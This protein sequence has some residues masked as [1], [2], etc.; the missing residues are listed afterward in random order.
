MDKEIDEFLE[1][2]E[3]NPELVES[4]LKAEVIGSNIEN[5]QKVN[6]AMM[7]PLLICD[8]PDIELPKVPVQLNFLLPTSIRKSKEPYVVNIKHD[9]N[10]Y[11]KLY[12]KHSKQVNKVIEKTKECIKNLYQPLK[13]L[14]NDIKN[15]SSNFG[16]TIKQI[17][18]PLKNK[19]MSLNRIDETKY[20][21]DKQKQFKGDK[22]KILDEIKSYYS[23][24]QTFYENYEKI[25]K[26]TL[27]EIEEFVQ[28]F[29]DLAKP[30]QEL[31]TFM[32][33]LFKTF[34][35]SGNQF[36]DLSKKEDIEAA[37]QKIKEPISEF[38]K[39]YENIKDLLK[40]VENI[41]KEKIENMNEIVLKNKEIMT[42][43]QNKSTNISDKITEIR[44]KYGEKEEVLKSMDFVDTKLLSISEVS[45]KVEMQK[46]E[47]DKEAEKKLNSLK[48]DVDSIIRQSRLDLLFIMDITNSMDNYLDEA[49]NGILA[50]IKKIQIECPGS[51]IFL[52]FIG[53][54]DFNDL[55]FGEKYIN[56]E[57]TTDYEK[58]KNNIS[59]LKAEGGGDT[60]ED[61]CGAFDL[62]KNKNWT[63]KTRFAI[64][65]TDSPCHGEKYHDLKKGEDN[66]PNGERDKGNIE[67][68][69][70]F[71]AQNE[72]SLYCLKIN[73]ST[74]KMFKIFKDIYTKN[75]DKN[76]KNEFVV[77]QGKKIF[78]IVTE[79]TI[80]S[81]QNRKHLEIKE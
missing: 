71:F 1:K 54:K 67:D 31:I 17:S 40:K 74:D 52:G 13:N 12:E 53:Y 11:R 39:K 16:N 61:L 18:T 34:E 45:E 14:G 46:K 62:A 48:N 59:F 70:K 60:A 38:Y 49:K 22:K 24:A 10:M 42:E 77:E 9:I 6:S 64:L 43:L 26:N 58:I 30:A 4:L 32:R 19:E 23:E 80:K 3:T 79:N 25:N 47:I 81:F 41:K 27:S 21:K 76:S 5:L 65:V 51:E 55:D 36:N 56:L 63:G 2:L 7:K 66:Y 44:K 57:F 29:M 33:K 35:K 37:L 8:N 15:I 75:K 28:Q 68:Y 20:S 73:S 72:I 50:M 78:N 69:I